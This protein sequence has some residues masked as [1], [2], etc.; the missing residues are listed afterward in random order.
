MWKLPVSILKFSLT[1]PACD[2]YHLLDT[3]LLGCRM[4]VLHVVEKN[5]DS[6]SSLF[7]FFNGCV[8]SAHLSSRQRVCMSS[9]ELRALAAKLEQVS[10]L[11]FLLKALTA[12]P[13]QVSKFYSLLKALTAKLEQVSKFYN[14]LKALTAKLE[15]VTKFYTLLKAVLRIRIRDRVLFDPWIQDPE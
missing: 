1:F 14:L 15:Q 5:L 7:S 3:Y 9:P 10:K 6:S 2:T 8:N 13:E 12:K 11:F 4:Y